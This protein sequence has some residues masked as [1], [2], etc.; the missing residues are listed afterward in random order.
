VI[1]VRF[2]EADAISKKGT[3]RQMEA[4]S[5]H[6]VIATINNA[7]NPD[8]V[9]VIRYLKSVNGFVTEGIERIFGAK[10]LLI[11]A[12]LAI[13]EF[14]LIGTIV[15]AILEKLSQAEDLGLEFCYAPVFEVLGRSYTLTEEGR[16]MKLAR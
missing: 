10:D 7:N 5:H 8:Q 15:S 1:E 13:P 3:R 14:E 2:S 11:P 16:Y 6:D 4:D 9:V 12:H